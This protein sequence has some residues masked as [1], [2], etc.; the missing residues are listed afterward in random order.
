MVKALAAVF[1]VLSISF[2][3]VSAD[4][5]TAHTVSADGHHWVRS[6]SSTIHGMPPR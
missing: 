3:A 4:T 6:G 2:T 1:T 5:H